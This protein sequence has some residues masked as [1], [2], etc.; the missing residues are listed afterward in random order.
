MNILSLINFAKRVKIGIVYSK[1]AK[2][3]RICGVFAL[4]GGN[5]S[6]KCFQTV[7]VDVPEHP[8]NN[9]D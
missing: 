4:P 1:V 2:I 3:S 8:A 5:S 7:M 9:V 6:M